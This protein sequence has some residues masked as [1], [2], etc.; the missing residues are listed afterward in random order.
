[1]AATAKT[2]KE[3][4]QLLPKTAQRYAFQIAM[5]RL[6]NS[7]ITRQKTEAFNQVMN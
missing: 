7:P 1:M 5:P 4:I 3:K 6:L 2:T